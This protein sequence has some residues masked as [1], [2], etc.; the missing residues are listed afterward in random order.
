MKQ[1]STSKTTEPDRREMEAD[2]DRTTRI[3]AEIESSLTGR[4]AAI[5]SRTLAE[6][7]L[8]YDGVICYTPAL[9]CALT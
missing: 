9:G 1:K 8:L 4:P 6:E 5:L 2:F 3:R 7:R